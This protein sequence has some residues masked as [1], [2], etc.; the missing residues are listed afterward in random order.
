MR[1]ADALRAGFVDDRETTQKLIVPRMTP[2]NAVEE[3]LVDLV[4]DFEVAREQAAEEWQRPPLERLS[5][6][7]VV[8]VTARPLRDRPGL[9]PAHQMLVDE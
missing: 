5:E 7:R 2:A 8:S 4:D 1:H 9:V 6:K 3:A